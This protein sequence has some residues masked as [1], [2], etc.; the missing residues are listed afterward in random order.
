MRS[1]HD[2]ELRGPLLTFRALNVT[3]RHVS[4]CSFPDPLRD[5]VSSLLGFSRLS[6]VFYCLVG[7]STV[8][9]LESASTL[10]APNGA[11]LDRQRHP[12]LET[13]AHFLCTT[14]AILL[15]TNDARFLTLGA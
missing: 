14:T 5:L 15:D 13:D 11:L 7:T 9:R 10:A 3:P 12:R 2:A 8:V 4:K 6:P 1:V